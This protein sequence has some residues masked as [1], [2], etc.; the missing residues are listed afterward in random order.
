MKNKIR[1]TNEED[2]NNNVEIIAVIITVTRYR[3]INRSYS[4][5][6]EKV[7]G[8]AW[9]CHSLCR[10]EFAGNPVTIHAYSIDYKS[11]DNGKQVCSKPEFIN[12]DNISG[13]IHPDLTII[14]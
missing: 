13:K 1:V 4:A 10:I 2:S 6:V 5:T 11:V 7:I 12:E 8:I 14:C 9:A 3:L